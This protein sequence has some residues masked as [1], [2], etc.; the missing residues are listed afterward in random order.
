MKA[1]GKN[2]LG[3]VFFTEDKDG[4]ATDRGI[5]DE[6]LQDEAKIHKDLVKRG[7]IKQFVCTPMKDED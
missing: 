3:K 2:K 4:K 7:V 6:C 5:V 1:Q